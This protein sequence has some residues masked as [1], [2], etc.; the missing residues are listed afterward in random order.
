MS[1][2]TPTIIVGACVNFIGI[3]VVITTIMSRSRPF[4]EAVMYG[5]ALA[6][7]ATVVI[8]IVD[9]MT[10]GLATRM[11]FMVYGFTLVLMLVLVIVRPS[12]VLKADGSLSGFYL[13]NFS[14]WP[15]FI[16]G[17][18]I[19]LMLAIAVTFLSS[20]FSSSIMSM[21]D[22]LNVSRL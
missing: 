15:V 6:L 5:I 17:M 7:V 14:F 18:L 12:F 1:L 16:T 20:R 11:M 8:L 3:S 13:V 22:N 4:M 21:V 19:S 10:R 2:S 9:L